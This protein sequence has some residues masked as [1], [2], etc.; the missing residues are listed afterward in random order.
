MFEEKVTILSGRRVL[1]QSLLGQIKKFLSC[2]G[3]SIAFASSQ[4]EP[5][6]SQWKTKEG[7]FQ[8]TSSKE[9]QTRQFRLVIHITLLW[10]KNMVKCRSTHTKEI[11]P[12]HLHP[13]KQIPPY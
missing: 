13:I 10:I 6:E 3:W 1:L 7:T 11:T 5:S 8:L 9:N 2:L 4:P 12:Y